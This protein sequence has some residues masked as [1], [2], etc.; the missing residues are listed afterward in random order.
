MG[1][2]GLIDARY[3]THGRAHPH[4][5]PNKNTQNPYGAIPDP[6]LPQI[7]TNHQNYPQPPK[8]FTRQHTTPSVIIAPKD[9]L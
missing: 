3:R 7:I 1:L 4:V 6:K 5:N 8:I 9:Y 2:G